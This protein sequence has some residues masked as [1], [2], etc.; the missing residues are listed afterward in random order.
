VTYNTI[1]NHSD[2]L[3]LISDAYYSLGVLYNRWP[4]LLP[5]PEA[6]IRVLSASRDLLSQCDTE[7][8]QMIWMVY[9]ALGDAYL[10]LQAP[11]PERCQQALPCFRAVIE[12][13]E[14]AGPL[15]TPRDVQTLAAA[16]LGA[17]T[18]YQGL[19]ERL[20]ALTAFDR[21]LEL[22]GADPV[23][24]KQA[25]EAIEQLARERVAGQAA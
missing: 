11:E 25:A 5:D 20:R 14:A 7:V 3:T 17:G 9:L 24:L 6:A 18:A 10:K 21:V 8:P 19:G 4:T 16:Y 1:P 15:R 12:H 13:F 22:Q 23:T 2:N